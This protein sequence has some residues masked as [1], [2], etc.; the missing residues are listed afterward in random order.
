MFTYFI[1]VS[2][3]LVSSATFASE[4]GPLP[5]SF[6]QLHETHATYESLQASPS[7][8]ADELTKL[9]KQW[10]KGTSFTDVTLVGEKDQFFP[11]KIRCIS[12]E[13]NDYYIGLAQKMIVDA[14]FARVETVVDHFSDYVGMFDGL[15]HVEMVSA[16]GNKLVT[17]FEEN[18]PIPFVPN[19]KDQMI[20]I[21]SKP[22]EGFKIYRYGLKESNHLTK[23]D[24]FIVLEAQPEGKTIYTEYDFFDADWGIAKSVGRDKIWQDSVEGLLQSD[25]ALKLASEHADWTKKQ[26]FWESK[27]W[28]KKAS[29]KSCIAEKKKFSLSP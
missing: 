23:S 8:Y 1:T 10:P 9:L 11:L 24:G 14:P 12:T 21:I 29:V 27:D 18:I 7:K 3:I 6:A 2:S 26:V 5:K 17:S 4:L 15:V 16:D 28:L 25:L 20:Y 13:G 19:E 22:K